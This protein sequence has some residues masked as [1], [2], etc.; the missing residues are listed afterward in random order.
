M[1]ILLAPDKFKDSLS[2]RQVCDALK[3]GIEKSIPNAEIISFPLADGGEG[4]LEVARELLSLELVTIPVRD[5][6][7]RTVQAVYGINMQQGIALI[8]MSRA[9]GIQ[10]LSGPERNAEHT[11]T[12]G[13]GELIRDALSRGITK[14]VLT[15]GGSA[16]SEAGI[17]MATA[18]G[19][20]FLDEA[21]NELSPIGANLVRIAKI[22]ASG[23]DSRMA[24]CQFVV[25]TDVTNPL[26]GPNG[27]AFV[28][29]PQKGVP[30]GRIP[31]LDRGL[32]NIAEQAKKWLNKDVAQIPGA[33]AAGGMGA[34]AMLFLYATVRKGIDWIMELSGFDAALRDADLVITGEGRIDRQTASGKV[35]HGVMS[36]AA[37][38]GKRVI[39]VCGQ[40]DLTRPEIAGM[41]LSQVFSL[42][43]LAGSVGQALRQP[44]ELLITI[45][46]DY[47]PD[48]LK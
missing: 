32:Q 3:T 9:S 37:A 28:Y 5:P 11:T 30:P 1:K 27:A 17:G 25:L 45:G 41:G 21:G 26:Y 7:F 14:I 39:G 29:G 31:V 2:A 18:L 22:D 24:G 6:L 16:T 44:K 15:L 40:C 33:G 36:H 42:T 47:I 23:A 34:G 35:V 19:Y 13:T 46:Q 4:T 43:E 38:A 48:H 12:F 10:L 20:R 8:E